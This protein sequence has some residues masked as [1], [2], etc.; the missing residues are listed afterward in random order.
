M[1]QIKTRHV[2]LV[3]ISLVMA[4][5][6]YYAYR[7]SCS[8]DF[9]LCN[10]DGND[11]LFFYNPNIC[12][13]FQD[14]HEWLGE[15]SSGNFCVSGFGFAKF[16]KSELDAKNQI[17]KRTTFF[18]YS[19]I[20]RRATWRIGEHEIVITHS[21]KTITI[22]GQP[23]EY[24]TGTIVIVKVHSDSDFKHKLVSY[25]MESLVESLSGCPS[26]VPPS[27]NTEPNTETDE[28]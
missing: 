27:K 3:I 18:S 5:L 17:T 14:R 4:H 20:K 10:I 22:D 8:W 11:A 7:S 13:L 2:I 24:D 25:R 6:M 26:V 9:K 15:S 28:N 21:G 19:P 23:V 16:T 1:K 12:F